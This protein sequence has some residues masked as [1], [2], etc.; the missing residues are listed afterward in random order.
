[1]LFDRAM[2][3]EHV[4]QQG[5]Q[6]QPGRHVEAVRI[7]LPPVF[8]LGKK[9]QQGNRAQQQHE[10]NHRVI[11]RLNGGSDRRAGATFF[12]RMS[13]IVMLL[14]IVVVRVV[15]VRVIVVPGIVLAGIDDHL[16][17]VLRPAHR[18]RRGVTAQ[19]QRNDKNHRC[20]RRTLL[21]VV[22]HAC[23]SNRLTRASWLGGR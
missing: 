18:G 5:S 2:I 1:M 22:R 17:A 20:G 6:A 11:G 16:R 21:I 8:G 9:R 14:L 3:D 12:I 13:V 15:V 19:H 10:G 7:A 23:V 4:V